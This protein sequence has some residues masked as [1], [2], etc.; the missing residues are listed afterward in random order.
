MQS[1]APSIMHMA[2]QASRT[3]QPDFELKNSCMPQ[4]MLNDPLHTHHLP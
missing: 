1:K 4:K 2:V 3:I